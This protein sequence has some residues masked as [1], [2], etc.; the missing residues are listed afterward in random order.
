[1]GFTTRMLHNPCVLKCMPFLDQSPVYLGMSYMDHF[2]YYSVSDEVKRWLEYGIASKLKV[3]FMGSVSW[4]FLG[5]SYYDWHVLPSGK[6][7]CHISQK[8]FSEQLLWRNLLKCRIACPVD[9][10]FWS[11]LPINR[12]KQENVNPEDKIQFTHKYQSLMGGII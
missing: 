1:M 5:C 2:V 9:R 12:I 11:G 8:A 4:W 6:L 3:D 10:L 7:N